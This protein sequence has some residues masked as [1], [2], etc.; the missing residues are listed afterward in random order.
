MSDRGCRPIA[1]STLGR[2]PGRYIGR[3]SVDILYKIHDPSLES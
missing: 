1:R 2:H 3:V